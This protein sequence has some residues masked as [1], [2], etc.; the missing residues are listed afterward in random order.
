MYTARS[1]GHEEYAASGA[2]MREY[3][4]MYL[5][6]RQHA[7]RRTLDRVPV[8]GGGKL[9]DIGCNYGHFLVMAK[10]RGW[11]V[12]GI[13]PGELVRER[14]LPEVTEH[15]YARLEEVYAHSP[16]D[17]ITMWDVL[18]HIEDPSTMLAKLLPLLGPSGVLIVRVPDARIFQALA[19][20]FVWRVFGNSYLKFCHPTNPEEHYHHFTVESLAML[21]RQRGLDPIDTWRSDSRE[22]VAAGR[23]PLDGWLRRAGHLLGRNLPY[24]FTMMLRVASRTK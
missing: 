12:Y 2:A 3:V 24:E 9:L 19:G 16:F 11:G 14:A 1:V 7:Y 21:A 18:E 10:E 5:P 17:A 15:V 6:A 23:T 8:V 4:R 22:R 13:E 20:S